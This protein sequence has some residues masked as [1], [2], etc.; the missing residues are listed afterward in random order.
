[1]KN[2][3]LS[4]VTIFLFVQSA[5]AQLVDTPPY[6]VNHQTGVQSIIIYVNKEASFLNTHQTRLL[7]EEEVESVKTRANNEIRD[8]LRQESLGYTDVAFTVFP[9]LIAGKY[10]WA[11]VKELQAA[12]AELVPGWD[13]KTFDRVWIHNGRGGGGRASLG[14][15]IIEGAPY[16]FPGR[17]ELGHTYGVRH[18]ITFRTESFPAPF[19]IRWGWYST[20]DPDGLQYKE[21]VSNGTYRVY[22]E[23]QTGNKKKPGTNRAYRLLG[24]Y[25]SFYK[26]VQRTP[27]GG[28][29][30]KNER[31]VIY[32]PGAGGISN[33]QVDAVLKVGESFTW[34]YSASP[35]TITPTGYGK[36]NQSQ[37]EYMDFTVQTNADFGTNS[38]PW[39]GFKNI[40]SKQV[41]NTAQEFIL[42]ANDKDGEVVSIE[43]KIDGK[44][45]NPIS[46]MSLL[47]YTVTHPFSWLYSG[48]GVRYRYTP[49]STG[50]KEVSVKITDDAGNIREYSYPAIDVVGKS[51]EYP[52]TLALS[53]TKNSETIKT[54]E[55]VTINF[56]A[57]TA[58]PAAS[59]PKQ[60]RIYFNEERITVYTG[61]NSVVV[62]PTQAGTNTIK[63]ALLDYQGRLYEKLITFNVVENNLPAP[64]VDYEDA[65]TNVTA[66]Q[67]VT[68]GQTYDIALDYSSST[69]R[70]ITVTFSEKNAPYTAYHAAP[71]RVTVSRGTGKLTIPVTIAANTPKASGKYQWQV[72]ITEVGKGYNEQKD[73]E[74]IRN[75]SARESSETPNPP[76]DSDTEVNIYAAGKSGSERMEL[77][78]D[79]Q[80]VKV[81]NAVGGNPSARNFVSYSHTV[82]GTVTASQITVHFT[83]DQAERD[84]RVDKIEVNGAGYQSEAPATY[85]VG[86]WSSSDACAGGY[87]QSEWL[88]CAGYFAYNQTNA[89]TAEVNKSKVSVEEPISQPVQ[90]FPNPAQDILRVRLPSY[91]DEV[92]ITLTDLMGRQVLQHRQAG[93]QLVDLSVQDLSKGLYQVSVRQAQ[94]QTVHRLLIE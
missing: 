66:P 34:E 86:S 20:N 2:R 89:R 42:I 41:V 16:A 84:L 33:E 94:Q 22:N 19:R 26:G 35:V 24:R 8:Y 76:S 78:V 48:Y 82:S 73:R 12:A 65:L 79:G 54:W 45:V 30:D 9:Y 7:T 32:K 85:S 70:D 28:P 69:N 21:I 31:L 44:L 3:L 71:G 61:D 74:D 58:D 93:S 92:V 53:V 51:E 1:M 91:A 25:I 50:E 81:W 18:P 87:K 77:R 36:D 60:Q 11:N 17:H 6:S 64:V 75:V 38:Q 83:N 46:P 4:L 57:T 62:I 68:A 88:H 80:T 49:T 55:P 5:F 37:L 39:V 14:G 90:L 29:L 27:E 63:Y 10:E 13:D 40:P 23:Y 67:T 15:R 43:L 72:L 47:R 59:K 52:Y 56:S